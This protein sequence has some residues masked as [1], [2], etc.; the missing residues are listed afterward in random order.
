[1]D[2]RLVKLIHCSSHLTVT[3]CWIRIYTHTHTPLVQRKE[4]FQCDVISVVTVTDAKV[5]GTLYRG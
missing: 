1:M 3:L 4:V 5:S 2:N